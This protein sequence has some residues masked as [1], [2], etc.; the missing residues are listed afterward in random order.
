MSNLFE[1]QM[2]YMLIPTSWVFSS[3]LSK[4]TIGQHS[5]F[6]PAKSK[7]FQA[8]QG[9]TWSISYGD[10]SGAAGSVGMDVV[11]IGGATATR[12]A[13][14]LATAVSQSFAKDA[15]N[16]GLVGLAFSKLNTIKPTKQTTFFDSVMPQLAMPV[17]SVDLKND[18]TGTYQFGAIDMSKAQGPL[19]TIPVNAESGFWQVDSPTV[20][21]GNQKVANQGGS[22]A[23][24]GKFFPI[25][26]Y[27]QILIQPIDTGT[28]LLLVDPQVAN[29]YYAKVQGATNNAQVGGFTYP[30]NAQLPDFGVAMGPSYTAMVPGNAITFA[31]VDANTCFG[32][33]QSNGGANLQIYGDVMFRTQYVVFDG[34]NKAL[35]MAPKK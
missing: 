32:G 6:D 2:N 13:V 22:P 18:S 26:F 31:Q 34:Q 27:N 7:S 35:M 5:A 8:M 15:N 16:D 9:A 17:F 14:E 29:A 12:Q 21:I 30:C 3:A 11:E 23:I 10:G 25:Q 28:S 1:K 24:A 19:T 20:T 33:V 4:Q